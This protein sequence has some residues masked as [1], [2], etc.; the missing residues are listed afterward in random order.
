MSMS[1][2]I[3]LIEVLLLLVAGIVFFIFKAHKKKQAETSL[4]SSLLRK[5]DNEAVDRKAKFIDTFK[6]YGVEDDLA[7]SN[8][9]QLIDAEKACIQ[10]FV[11]IQLKSLEDDISFFNETVYEITSA[12]MKVEMLNRETTSPVSVAAV[13]EVKGSD[14]AIDLDSE[15]VE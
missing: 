5:L 2:A 11:S 14:S 8:A 15:D 4:L 9:S 10:K 13:S 7:T 6:M 12:Y 1:V 3:I